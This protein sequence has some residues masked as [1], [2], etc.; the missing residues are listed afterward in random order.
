MHTVPAPFTVQLAGGPARMSRRARYLAAQA[1]RRRR[2]E[3][4]ARRVVPGV[5]VEVTRPTDG[6]S[7]RLFVTSV[8]PIRAGYLLAYGYEVNLRG[9]AVGDDDRCAV[10][11]LGTKYAVRHA[12]RSR[13]GVALTNVREALFGRRRRPQMALV[14]PA[15]TVTVHSDMAGEHVRSRAAFE[16]ALGRPMRSVLPR[17]DDLHEMPE[18]DEDLGALDDDEQPRTDTL[19][20]IPEEGDGYEDVF[21]DEPADGGECR[22]VT[23][24]LGS[25]RYCVR[26]GHGGCDRDDN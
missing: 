3:A 11:D 22:I 17:T 10:L 19:Y 2:N 18:P 5:I 21:G 14:S 6:R 9:R 1:E 24:T 7:V 8:R 12:R 26:C 4:R 15:D 16:A 25:Q 20:E 23:S 13:W